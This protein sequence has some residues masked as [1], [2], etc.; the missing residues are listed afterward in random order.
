MELLM[1]LQETLNSISVK[2]SKEDGC[3]TNIIPKRRMSKSR[4]CLKIV[5]W[6]CVVQQL[7]GIAS[8]TKTEMILNE[9][10]RIGA[11]I[12]KES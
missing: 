1:L 7:G 3:S 9:T 4:E 10:L 2:I 6:K 8:K 11:D 5:N 12:C